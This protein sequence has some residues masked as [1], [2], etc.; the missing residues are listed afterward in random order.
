MRLFR[1]A[2]PVSSDTGHPGDDQLLSQLARMSDIA[3]PRHWVHY[4]SFADETG[5]RGAAEVVETAGWELQNVAESATGGHEWVVVAERRG[6]VTS[7]EAVYDARVFF[8]GV[9]QQWRGGHY[10]GWRASA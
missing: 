9:A 3:A 2:K 6:A 5:A 4:L 1:R 8:E 10:D 7:P